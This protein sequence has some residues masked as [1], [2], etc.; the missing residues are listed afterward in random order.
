VKLPGFSPL[1]MGLQTIFG[2][3]NL[4]ICGWNHI[5]LVKEMRIELEFMNGFAANNALLVMWKVTYVKCRH[6]NL[7]MNG[8]QM[9][10]S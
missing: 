4:V 8:F 7:Q 5:N 10:C 9:R 2:D 6:T 3:R 1:C